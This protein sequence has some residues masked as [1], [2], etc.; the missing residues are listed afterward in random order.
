MNQYSYWTDLSQLIDRA[1]ELDPDERLPFLRTSC[2][3]NPELFNAAKEYLS[4]IEQAEEEQFLESNVRA[5]SVLKSG[6]ETGEIEEAG[7][8]PVKGCRVGPYEIREPAGEGGMGMVYLAERADGEFDQTVAIKFL[9]GGFFSPTMRNR[10][11]REKQIL[12]KLNHPNIAGIIDG[13][14][15]EDGT[16]YIILEYVKGV[17]V[18]EYCEDNNLR[19]TERLNLF[20]QICK[21][22]QHA[23]SQLIIHRDL[24]P[25]NI[26]VT[27]QGLVKVMD[28]GIAKFLNPGHGES[29]F[30]Q[31]REGSHVASMEFAAP[32]QFSSS[33][34]TTATDVYGLGVLLYLMTTGKKPFTFDGLSLTEARCRIET[35]TP[36]DPTGQSD[37]GIGAIDSDLKVILLKALRKEAEMRYETVL[38]FSADLRRYMNHK[39]VRARSG[40]RVYRARKFLRRN[41]RPLITAAALLVMTTG[42]VLFHLHT[43]NQQMQQTAMEAETSQAVTSFIVDLFDISDPVHNTDRVLTANSLLQRGQSRFDGLDLKPEVQLQLLY[44]LG[45]ASI[46]LGDYNNAET[47][48]FKADS[49][50]QVHYPATSYQVAKASLNLGIIHTWHRKFFMGEHY[51]ARAAYYYEENPGGYPEEYAELLLQLGICQINIRTPEQAL[52]TLSQALDISRR[53][54]TDPQQ[55]LRTELR[56]A[57]A[58]VQLEEFDRAEKIYHHVLL[59]IEEQG[60]NRYDIHRTALNN[61]GNLYLA[62]MEYESAYNYYDAAKN[63]AF[64]IYGDLHPWFLKLNY[65]QLYLFLEMGEFERALELSVPMMHGKITRHGEQSEM[66]ADGYSIK[67]LIFFLMGDFEQASDYFETSYLIYR[68][69]LGPNDQWTLLQQLFLSF[70]LQ[71]EGES[72]KSATNFYHAFSKLSSESV[73]LEFFADEKLQQYITYFDNTYPDKLKNKIDILREAGLVPD[74]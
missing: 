53:F 68:N 49:I 67:A 36:P 10:F 7:K 63:Q 31:T 58:Y 11:R 46:R 65:N 21:A 9:R 1:L 17:P 43:I 39:P 18:D 38:E 33:D 2:S 62:K 60:F 61:L 15:T 8:R 27:D 56:Q 29:S 74:V 66:A 3:G 59:K 54:Q 32:E 47:I 57:E 72:D 14:I 28:F 5:I 48:F 12:A 64:E 41:L 37:P 51:L 23:H 4:Y 13:G 42:F 70:S 69:L 26:F 16:P 34:P 35:E 30:A 20:L 25:D 55:P 52:S 73:E 50:A 6:L 44:E 19:M 22:V 24:K 45:K 71:L 40:T